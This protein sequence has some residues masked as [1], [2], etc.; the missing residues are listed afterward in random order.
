MKHVQ[1]IGKVPA[2]Q[3]ADIS[4]GLLGT[5]KKFPTNATKTI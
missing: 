2:P 1:L 3:M 5:S 4:K